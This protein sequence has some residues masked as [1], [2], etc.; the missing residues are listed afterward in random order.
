MFF[1]GYEY[2]FIDVSTNDTRLCDLSTVLAENR[3]D[4]LGHA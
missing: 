4:R 1:L 2:T 3:A